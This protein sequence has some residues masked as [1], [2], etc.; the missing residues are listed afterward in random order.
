[1]TLL[2]ADEVIAYL[3][4][5]GVLP[6]D[7][8]ATLEVLSGGVSSAVFRVECGQAAVVV[9][10][11]LPQLRVN[12]E[13][14]SR[15][16]RSATEARAAEAFSNLLP[17]GSV[18]APVYVDH[19]RSLFVMPGVPRAAETWKAKLMRGELARETAITVGEL[20]GTLH[21]RSR[22]EPRFQ[23]AFADR[24]DFLALRVDPYLRVTAERRPDLAAAIDRHTQRMLQVRECLVHGD[25]SPK[26]VLVRPDRPD[27]VV[28]L[29]HEVTHWGD[30]TF[31]TAFCLTHLHLKACTFPVRAE[32]F[33][34]LAEQFWTSYLR[35]A[36]VPN[37]LACERDTVGLLGC[38][39]AARVDGKSPAE[40]LTTDVLRD[41]VRL[42]ART[43][44]LEDLRTLQ[45]VRQT[46]LDLTAEAIQPA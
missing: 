29:D 45:A 2:A 44:L 21:F 33:L 20:L 42:L 39:L 46:T 41:R 38:L 36:Q 34:N 27:R 24:Q 12:D 6:P 22:G 40:Y 23:Q 10:Q 17:P 5:V 25:Y 7:A 8:T 3:R 15:V 35:A 16:E 32:N 14:L 19:V 30:P 43:I 13:W 37:P 28:L 11:A 26:N 1:M 31:D 9:K 4:E 18:L